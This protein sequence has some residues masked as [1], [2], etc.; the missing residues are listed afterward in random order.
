[1]I[2]VVYYSLYQ[3]HWFHWECYHIYCYLWTKSLS[4]IRIENCNMWVILK[5]KDYPFHLVLFTKICK[6][7]RLIY[8]WCCPSFIGRKKY[9]ST[10]ENSVKSSFT[11]KLSLFIKSP[12]EKV[13]HFQRA[14]FDTQIPNKCL[15]IF[16]NSINTILLRIRKDFE[17]F[18]G[19]IRN[20]WI[21]NGLMTCHKQ[22][23]KSY[24]FPQ[25]LHVLYSF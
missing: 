18:H 17:Y 7:P 2:F 23:G 4:W 3:N 8:L 22:K 21:P 5:V 6:G 12:D 13:K 1:M 16:S 24:F 15:W 9:L 14:T 20:Q 10:H 19:N 11:K 25:T